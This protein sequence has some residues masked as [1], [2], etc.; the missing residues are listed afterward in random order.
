MTTAS[1]PVLT[2]PVRT[3]RRPLLATARLLRLELCHNAMLWMLPVAIGVFWS[4]SYR[5]TMDTPPLWYLRATGL[6]SG[7]VA[8][9]IIPVVGAAAWMG[10]REGR[11]RITDQV[12]ITARPRWARLLLAWAA[13][14]IWALVGYGVCLAVVYGVTARQASWGGPLWWPVLVTAASVAAFSALG[15][16]S[17]SLLPGRLTPP[18]AAIVSFF[19]LV[20]STELINGGQSYWQISP[21]VAGPWESGQNPGV[22]TFYPYLPDLSIAQVMFLAG[23]TVALL[24]AVAIPASGRRARS[25]AAAAAAAGVV[26]ATTA[27]VLAGTGTLDRDGMIAVPALHD[28]ASDRPI[29]FTPV[30]SQSAIPV[31]L[32]P[33]YAGY[34]PAVAAT[35]RP[36]LDEIAGLPG[37]PSRIDQA[38]ATYLQGSGNSVAVG[39]VGPQV[40]AGEYRMLLPDQFDGSPLTIRQLAGQVR[41]T[42][43]PAIVASFVGDGPGA[44]EAQQ[45]V[46]A[47]LSTD[48]GLPAAVVVVGPPVPRGRTV[49]T[50]CG[51]GTADCSAGGTGRLKD[52]S[53]VSAAA[54]RF[55]ALPLA[56]RRAWL[57]QHLTALRAGQVTLAELP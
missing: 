56:A 44:S 18:A 47:A 48:A 50:R 22:A 37:A 26:A 40:R 29:M 21:I 33:A 3:T 9:F 31:C 54:R 36:V 34:L 23:V 6:Q 13:T 43:G 11:R 19:V 7:I 12:G 42:T 45:A 28:A 20:L 1:A 41:I 53:P 49:H 52:D 8:D 2:R 5:K 25:A 27:V 46:E 15:F 14:A 35:L 55:A 24:G 39:L 38:A 4:F 17:G 32:N 51:G 30:C 10:S 16:A 57:A